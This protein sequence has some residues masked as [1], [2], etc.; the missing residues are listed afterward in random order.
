MNVSRM[1]HIP[2]IAAF[3]LVFTSAVASAKSHHGEHREKGRSLISESKR[4]SF[5]RERNKHDTILK[6]L[7]SS[8][9]KLE[10]A[11]W[12]FNPSDE[13]SQ[14]NKGKV[15]MLAPYGH[16][17]NSDRKKLC[18]NNGRVIKEIEPTPVPEPEPTPV[19]EPEPTPVP[20]PEPTPVPEPEPTP[21]PEPEPTPVP[22]PE[23]TPVPEP[24]P[25]PVPEPEPTPVPEPEPTPE[26]PPSGG[27][28]LP[29]AP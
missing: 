17:K 20:E 13:R 8:L 29:P 27:R 6:E 1:T 25:T 4:E 11:R 12:D 14:G 16:D 9:R 23:P 19:P 5:D 18:G 28:P 10:H 21:V 15:D 24:E 7:D 2:L 26:P 3:C 22:E